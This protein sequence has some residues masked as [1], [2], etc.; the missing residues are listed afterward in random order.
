MAV[1]LKV[2]AMRL[3]GILVIAPLGGWLLLRFIEKC[4]NNWKSGNRRKRWMIMCGVFII[5]AGIG[6]WLR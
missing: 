6:G 4:E 5:L 1:E 2:F 3:L